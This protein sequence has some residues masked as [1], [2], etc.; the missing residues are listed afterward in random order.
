MD[1]KYFCFPLVLHYNC[2]NICFGW[3]NILNSN[4]IKNNWITCLPPFGQLDVGV[5][6][7]VWDAVRNDEASLVEG[8]EGESS[9][10]R[11]D[12]W[13]GFTEEALTDRFIDAEA[14]HRPASERVFPQSQVGHQALCR[15]E[16]KLLQKNI[17]LISYFAQNV[18]CQRKMSNS[19]LKYN[20]V[21][22][23]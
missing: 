16:Q 19:N 9:G 17:T 1:Y 11:W 14:V 15:G 10:G 23:K 20:L 13:F 12:C 4:L 7:E 21:A 18:K 8:G 3:P 22:V 2:A 6:G 5:L